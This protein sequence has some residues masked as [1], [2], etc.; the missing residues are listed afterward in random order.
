MPHGDILGF[1]PPLVT[2]RSEVDEIVKLA[3]AAVDEVAAQVLT[4]A[5]SA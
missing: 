3:R 4:P 1:A 5:A 2:S